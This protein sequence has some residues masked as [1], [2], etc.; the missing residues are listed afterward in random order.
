MMSFE[1]DEVVLVAFPFTNQSTSKKRPAA[2]LS[3][4]EYHRQRQD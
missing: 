4:P 1:F 3:V 2:V